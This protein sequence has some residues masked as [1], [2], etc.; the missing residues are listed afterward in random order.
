LTRICTRTRLSL[1]NFFATIWLCGLL[2]AALRN[3][4]RLQ[5]LLMPKAQI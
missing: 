1:C 2:M 5:L 4:R 3:R